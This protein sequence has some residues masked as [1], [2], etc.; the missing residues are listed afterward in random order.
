MFKKLTAFFLILMI[1][2]PLVI[3][4]SD[5]NAIIEEDGD[6]YTVRDYQIS[7]EITFSYEDVLIEKNTI[8]WDEW[9]P[10]CSGLNPISFL[11]FFTYGAQ[12]TA[13]MKGRS[14]AKWPEAVEVFYVGTPDTGHAD[15]YYGI[16][17]GA[18]YKNCYSGKEN[19]LSK[20]LNFDLSFK[21]AKTFDPFALDGSPDN[22]V[23]L[24][25]S[26]DTYTIYEGSLY[27][28]TGG[29]LSISLP[30]IGE[31]TRLIKLKLTLGGEMYI[32]MFGNRIAIDEKQQRAIY[33]ENQYLVLDPP[34]VGTD[35]D[36]TAHLEAK[37]YY[38]IIIVITFTIKIDIIELEFPLE[39]PIN[40]YDSDVTWRFNSQTVS[41]DFPAVFLENSM[42]RFRNT[43]PGDEDYW[44]FDI[45]NIGE[46][47]LVG[48]LTSNNTE[49][50]VLPQHV[51][52]DPGES[53]KVHVFFKPYSEGE[54]EGIIEF[55][56]NDPVDP[57]TNIS[58]FGYSS[59]TD[60]NWNQV[61]EGEE[62][63]YKIVGSE[64]GCQCST[65]NLSTGKGDI[66]IF[67]IFITVAGL[68]I[69]SFIS[70]KKE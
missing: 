3:T 52:L 5:S 24:E 43:L 58:L 10:A 68:G 41:F 45:Q 53:T 49:F 64:S 37:T 7:E 19:E 26:L 4:A 40:A 62:P 23:T 2:I 34:L 15:M 48:K 28:L 57:V 30:L 27:D 51:R 54:K 21:D 12:T 9:T 60:T 50:I 35:M 47:E 66:G 25:D 39:F 55:V 36:I 8:G 16:E 44:E 14:I 67:L 11:L 70:L 61:K 17:M 22:P 32:E 6:G 18:K 63:S 31:L 13:E 59:E 69:I 38:D 20:W 42:H 1:M 33:T 29:A 65:V 56:S 46:R